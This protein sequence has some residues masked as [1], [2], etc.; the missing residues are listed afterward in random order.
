L[1]SIFAADPPVTI[2][3]T[4]VLGLLRE[5]EIFFTEKKCAKEVDPG[6][7]LRLKLF[8]LL[9]GATRFFLRGGAFLFP[10]F[11]LRKNS[12]TI[13]VREAFFLFSLLSFL[14]DGSNRNE[15]EVFSAN[16]WAEAFDQAS[17]NFSVANPRLWNW[18][19]SDSFLF[20]WCHRGSLR[21]FLSQRWEDF[22][23]SEEY[24]WEI[25]R[26]EK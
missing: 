17:R 11:F 3:Q 5:G 14:E 16:S 25:G 23:S 20:L 15:S 22:E 18:A 13:S 1:R 26:Q 7:V 24:S 12:T 10:F 19:T 9:G 6:V 8:F 4:I 21:C 2:N